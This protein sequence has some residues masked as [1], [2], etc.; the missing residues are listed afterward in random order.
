MKLR[1]QMIWL[2]VVMWSAKEAFG[3]GLATRCQTGG[4]TETRGPLDL[5]SVDEPMLEVLPWKL[6]PKSPP[7]RA[8]RLQRSY[9]RRRMLLWLFPRH[10]FWRR[11]RKLLFANAEVYG[12]SWVPDTLRRGCA[13]AVRLLTGAIEELKEGLLL[14]LCIFL[15]T[16][17]WIAILV[18]HLLYHQSAT[19]CVNTLLVLASFWQG[20]DTKMVSVFAWFAW[21]FHLHCR[22]R[23]L[24]RVYTLVVVVLAQESL[25]MLKMSVLF[26]LVMMA[27]LFGTNEDEVE[28]DAVRSSVKLVTRPAPKDFIIFLCPWAPFFLGALL[29]AHW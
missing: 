9:G 14:L 17:T 11:G 23:G 7:E 13:F 2:L 10:L 21:A 1:I 28:E 12:G 25:D 15:V 27:P 5:A 20:Y 26:Y 18:R 6:F 24:C 29:V 8:L 4:T 16:P 3:V 19:R 22:S